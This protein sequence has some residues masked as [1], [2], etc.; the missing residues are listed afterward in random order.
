MSKHIGRLIELG[1]AK[2]AVRGAGAAPAFWLPKVGFTFDDKVTIARSQAGIGHLADSDEVFVV[3]KFG[4]GN[5]E[6]NMGDQSVGYFLYSLL[7]SLVSSGAV[8]SAYTHTLS[9][10]ESN[11]H[12]SL[13][14]VVKDPIS[15]EQYKLAMVNN[16]EIVAALD[17]I[18]KA[19]AT[20]LSKKGDAYSAVTPSY[21]AEKRFTKNHVK[22]KVAANIAGLAA[23]TELSIKSLRLTLNQNVATDDALN[24]AEPEDILNHHLSVEGEM[25]MN[26][27]DETF[28]NY[29]RTGAAK[30]MEIKF[31]NTDSL[32]GTSSKATLT[33][34]MPKV[35]FFAWEPNYGLNDIVR[36][37][38][39]F[40]ASYDVANAQNI[41][42][43][44]SLV[45]GKT[46]Y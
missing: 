15:T 36:Q 5:L 26:Y 45:N 7:G 18:V 42:S 27:E 16:L 13:C 41:I 44:C 20:F 32:I 31:E 19:T 46:S 30:S 38:I 43:S 1:I 6:M 24:T 8:D 2:E 28:K 35:D 9:L 10:L 21:V 3:N 34:Q 17:E 39:S 29:F 22:V 12:Q 14:L 37:T 23:A 25:V 40:K 4:Q 11:Q 33:L